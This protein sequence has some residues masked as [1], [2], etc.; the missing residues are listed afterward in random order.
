MSITPKL[1]PNT[2][3]KKEEITKPWKTKKIAEKKDI[4]IEIFAPE[5]KPAPFV[6]PLKVEEV[7]PKATKPE[8]SKQIEEGRKSMPLITEKINNYHYSSNKLVEEE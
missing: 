7:K 3:M 2:K 4:T 5:L 1:E 8:S 6:E